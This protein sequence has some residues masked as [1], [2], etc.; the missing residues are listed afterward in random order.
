MDSNHAESF[1]NLGVLELRKGNIE[2]AKS[3]FMTSAEMAEHTFEPFYNNALLSFK[4][5]D[6]Q[7]SF[8]QAGKALES[9]PD[10]S[11]SQELRKQLQQHF[12]LL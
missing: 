6:F 9:Y 11:D 3:N 8:E 12:T 5:G 7:E 1:N 2:S 4:L 10:H